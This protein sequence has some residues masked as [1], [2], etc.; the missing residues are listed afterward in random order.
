[1]RATVVTLT[2]AVMLSACDWGSPSPVPSVTRSNLPSATSGTSPAP[3]L[4]A[5]SRGCPFAPVLPA[6]LP[7]IGSQVPIPPPL[8]RRSLEP[9]GTVLAWI[10]AGPVPVTVSLVRSSIDPP[11]TA[12]TPVPVWIEGSSMGQLHDG[13]EPGTA[14]VFWSLSE[15]GTCTSITLRLAAPSMTT[16]QAELEVERIARSLEPRPPVVL[17][18]VR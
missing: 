11:A 12:G 16:T 13:A 6:H 17:V 7:W 8:S 9:G 10:S 4:P 15:A 1:M 5:L 14:F 2:L 3:P 18:H